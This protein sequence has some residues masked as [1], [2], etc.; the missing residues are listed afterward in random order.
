ML[1]LGRLRPYL[2]TLYKD[3]KASQGHPYTLAY[4]EH[5]LLPDNFLITLAHSVKTFPG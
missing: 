4:Y 2:Q 3:G 1:H 5:S